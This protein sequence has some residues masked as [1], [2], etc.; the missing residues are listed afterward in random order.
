MFSENA[1][2]I[3]NFGIVVSHVEAQQLGVR[4]KKYFF[5]FCLTGYG[6]ICV[7][8]DLNK[9]DFLNNDRNNA[10][11]FRTIK[12]FATGY[13]EATKRHKGKT[14]LSAAP[15]KNCQHDRLVALEYCSY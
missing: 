5:Y 6:L 11:E 7:W 4:V 10:R 12:N 13:Q 1:P 15:Y 2:S 3:D 9:H 8:C 14:Q